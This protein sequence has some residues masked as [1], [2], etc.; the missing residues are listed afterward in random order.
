MGREYLSSR[1]ISES[2]IAY[3]ESCNMVRYC[4]GGVLFCGYSKEGTI[5]NVTKRA[6]NPN[7]PVQKRNFKGSDKS[8]PAVLNGISQKVWIV[9]GGTDALAL[10]DIALRQGDAPPT[11]IVSGGANAVSFLQRPHI[12]EILS[13]AEKVTIAHE[14]EKN[15]ETQARTDAAHHKQGE[16]IKKLTNAKVVH[17]KPH[18]YMGKDIAEANQYMQIKG[19]TP[20]SQ[21]LQRAQRLQAL[22]VQTG[23][24]QIVASTSLLR[25]F[26]VSTNI[27]TLA[28]EKGGVGKTF[29]AVQLALYAAQQFKL[30]TLVIDLDSQGNASSI[31]KKNDQVLVADGITS[32]DLF[33]KDCSVTAA[34]KEHALVLVSAPASGHELQA[35][36]QSNDEV[37]EDMLLNFYNL[38]SAEAEKFDLVIIDTNPNADLRSTCAIACSTHVLCPIQLYQESVDGITGMC[39]RILGGNDKVNMFLI[40][41]MLESNSYQMKNAE[42]LINHL[43]HML[44]PVT[45]YVN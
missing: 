10:R 33:S 42:V 12:K 40:P 11:I 21:R 1:G 32:A 19:E 41:S 4:N 25:I 35:I 28:N 37:Q 34:D 45:E 20:F 9:E 14:N 31:L 27:I 43:S 16:L 26:T 22:K 15:L 3:A 13:Q 2:T 29:L 30:K 5:E 6:T 7:D 8:F 36:A 38:V 44:L 24:E 18:D 23:Y 17:W 39:E